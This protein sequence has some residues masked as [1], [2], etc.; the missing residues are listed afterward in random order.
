MLGLALRILRTPG[1]GQMIYWN[2]RRGGGIACKCP[3]GHCPNMTVIASFTRH[4]LILSVP[5]TRKDQQGR[6]NESLY[7]A[8]EHLSVQ[9]KGRHNLGEVVRY[10]G[11]KNKRPRDLEQDSSEWR[12]MLPS[13]RRGQ[14]DR[15]GWLFSLHRSPQWVP[16]TSPWSPK[17]GLQGCLQ[18]LLFPYAQLWWTA[19]CSLLQLQNVSPIHTL[20]PIPKFRSSSSLAITFARVS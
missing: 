12:E 9:R 5:R 7:P 15:Q 18:L 16:L 1:N 3:N 20:L 19:K 17:L 4:V 10:S 14:E 8:T 13:R 2:W 11:L 6:Q